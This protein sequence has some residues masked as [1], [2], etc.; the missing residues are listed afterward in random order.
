MATTTTTQPGD[1]RTQAAFD[2]V[3][4]CV[5]L[6]GAVGAIVLGTVAVMAFT[7]HEATPFMWIRGAI[8]LAVAP[9]IYRMVV[10]ASQGSYKAFD[11]VRT[12]STIAPIA[13]IG[14]DLIP[15]ICPPWY[16]VL[17][18]LSTLAL[19]GVAVTTRGSAL[20]AAFPKQK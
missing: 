2:T 17:Q 20:S 10:R 18:G 3:R 13:I 8:L 19:V 12:L 5:T 11:R 16:A 15:G 1:S 4:K 7:G 14:V 6:F 9:L